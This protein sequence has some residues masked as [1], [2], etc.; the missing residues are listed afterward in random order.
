MPCNHKAALQ[1]RA[2]F[3]LHSY[4]DIIHFA[5]NGHCHKIVFIRRLAIWLFYLLLIIAVLAAG[6]YFWRNIRL[7]INTSH[8]FID[9]TK[10]FIPK[11]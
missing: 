10:E 1:R 8:N 2:A 4:N 6:I 3:D 9:K 5:S 11:L 7:E